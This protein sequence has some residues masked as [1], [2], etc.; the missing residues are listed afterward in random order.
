MQSI[1]IK[2]PS[3]KSLTAKANLV[4]KP[5]VTV[6]GLQEN[7]ILFGD[8]YTDQRKRFLENQVAW[9]FL[10]DLAEETVISDGEIRRSSLS[11]RVLVYYDPLQTPFLKRVYCLGDSPQDGEEKATAPIF[12]F[13]VTHGRL[14]KSYPGITREA[15]GHLVD[16]KSVV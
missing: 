8:S 9:A 11:K 6:M 1:S 2:A 13:G 10:H 4:G 3:G 16:R 12:T 15:K 14:D 7:G 5:V